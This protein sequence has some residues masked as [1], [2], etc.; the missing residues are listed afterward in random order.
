MTENKRLLIIT[1]VWNHRE[2]LV[3]LMDSLRNQDT[4]DFQLLV[5][6]NASTDGVATFLQEEHPDVTVFRNFKN[7]GWAR[8][9]N[10]G[11]RLAL[12]HW[13]EDVRE[14]RFVTCIE[15]TLSLAPDTLSLLTKALASA[16]ELAMV[17]PKILKAG[18][19]VREEGE[20][21]EMVPTSILEST[22]MEMTKARRY[23]DRGNKEEDKGQ[24]DEKPDVFG[25]SGMCCVF[26]A[27]AL[28]KVEL[29][30]EWL[31]SDL[32]AGQ[33]M[34][35]LMWRARVRGLQ[36]RFVSKAV[37]WC[38]P[39]PLIA[40]ARRERRRATYE[41]CR[42]VWKNDDVSTRI[43]HAPW[44]LMGNLKSACVALL[45]PSLL[46]S[47]LVSWKDWLRMRRKR[48]KLITEPRISA[49]DLRRLF[50]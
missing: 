4:Q 30:G 19:N 45:H 34:W 5:I 48:K 23:Y 3:R 13:P 33:E 42:P 50:L 40:S 29:D 39:S 24:Y 9:M 6:D 32:P 28:K 10:Q 15:P 31:D 17:G 27:A 35:D 7:Q 49:K 11:I 1:V 20:D 44:I 43:A 14:D 12:D 37:A 2:A 22:G 41:R 26:R 47:F 8:A 38:V 18:W 21:A 16:P 25:L 46:A 36:P